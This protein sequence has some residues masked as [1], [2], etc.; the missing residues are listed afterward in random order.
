MTPPPRPSGRRCACA[1]P[2]GNGLP[3]TAI[4]RADPPYPA[5]ERVRG[6]VRGRPGWTWR[7]IA[8]GH[9]AMATA[10]AAL[11]GTLTEIG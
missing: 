3:R 5:P 1:S 7:E 4:A 11:A 10:P 6:E 8:A 9:D 2:V